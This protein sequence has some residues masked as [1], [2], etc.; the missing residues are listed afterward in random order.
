MILKI[1]LES[2]FAKIAYLLYLFKNYFRSIAFSPPKCTNAKTNTVTDD[3]SAQG[4]GPVK[5][6]GQYGVSHSDKN[7]LGYCDVW[8]SWMVE[9]LTDMQKLRMKATT[10]RDF[11]RQSFA[12]EMIDRMRYVKSE[13]V[14]AQG[15]LC[16]YKK[17]AEHQKILNLLPSVR[18][19]L[20]N[21]HTKNKQF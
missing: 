18:H 8:N 15:V 10:E 21:L 3:L 19:Q 13:I 1:F 5:A 4:D 16:C 7:V 20:H 9:T 14:N 17:S 12:Q 6:S 2:F 11:N